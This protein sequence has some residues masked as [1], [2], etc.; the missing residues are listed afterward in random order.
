MDWWEKNSRKWPTVNQMR[1]GIKKQER[2]QLLLSSKLDENSKEFIEAYKG[3]CKA[4]DEYF[5]EIP[6]K[7]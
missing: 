4:W 3:K 6:Q 7:F 2:V 5:D 1:D